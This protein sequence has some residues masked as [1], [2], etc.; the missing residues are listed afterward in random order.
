MAT[1]LEGLISELQDQ[2]NKNTAMLHDLK[3][4]QDSCNE[5]KNLYPELWKKYTELSGVSVKKLH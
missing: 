1:G 2:V 3:A 5:A 4:K